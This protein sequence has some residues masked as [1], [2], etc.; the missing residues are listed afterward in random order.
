MNI[1]E[2]EVYKK[3]GANLKSYRRA[4]GMTQAQ[5]AEKSEVQRT[6]VTNIEAGRQKAPVHVLFQ[7]CAALEVELAAVLPANAEVVQ[8]R[9]VAIEIDGLVHEM[10]PKAAASFRYLRQQLQAKRMGGED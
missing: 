2:Q 10:P 1:D 7:L 3:I 5:L 9:T 6:S 8:G 4:I